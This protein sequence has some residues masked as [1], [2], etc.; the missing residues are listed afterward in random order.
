MTDRNY[1]TW[2]T[3]YIAGLQMFAS[4][5]PPLICYSTSKE[6]TIRINSQQIVPTIQTNS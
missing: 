4:N 2:L 3:I 1:M 6:E 5:H